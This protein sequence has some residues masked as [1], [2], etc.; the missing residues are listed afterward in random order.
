MSAETLIRGQGFGLSTGSRAS[1]GTL[2]VANFCCPE[3]LQTMV[4][5][6]RSVWAQNQ[7]VDGLCTIKFTIQRDGKITD[8][9]VEREQRQH[10]GRSG[11]A[12]RSRS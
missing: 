10:R 8:T 1:G 4:Q 3:Y 9:S 5:R 12:P 11:G 2:D 6:I 7:G